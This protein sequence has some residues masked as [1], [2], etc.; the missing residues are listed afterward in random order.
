M[1][2]WKIISN[3]E[4]INPNENGWYVNDKLELDIIKIKRAN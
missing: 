4:I 1:G 3:R 2:E